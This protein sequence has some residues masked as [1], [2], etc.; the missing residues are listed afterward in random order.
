MRDETPGPIIRLLA[1]APGPALS[2][3]IA[4][5]PRLTDSKTRA[6]W[7]HHGPKVGAQT[8]WMLDDMITH[9]DGRGV[10]TP[11]LRA[12]RARLP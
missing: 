8:R 9:A 3:L 12:L 5:L 11:N 2:L 7:S 10:A 4:A 1:Y 6:M